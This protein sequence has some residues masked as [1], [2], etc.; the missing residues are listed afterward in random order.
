MPG[1]L[2][3]CHVVAC[4][5]GVMPTCARAE[6]DHERIEKL[7]QQLEQSTELIAR[8]SARI[9][10]LEQ[11]VHAQAEQVNAREQEDA[12]SAA[13]IAT[14]P[15]TPDSAPL[16]PAS[17]GI[18]L[19]AFADVGYVNSDQTLSDDRDSGFTMGNLD[20][21]LTPQIAARVKSLFELNFE[22]ESDGGLEVD[23]ERAQLGYTVGD[24][25][26]VWAGRFHTPFGYWNTAF[27]H[28]AQLQTSV[29]RPRFLEFEDAGG[30]LPA[31][32]VGLWGTGTHR[33]G[34]GRLYYDAYVG[35]G[36]RILDG[37]LD[38]NAVR[39]DNGQTALGLSLGY[40][41][42]LTPD[43]LLLG[44]HVLNENVNAYSGGNLVSRSRLRVYGGYAVYQPD[45]WEGIAEYYRFVNDALS[46]QGA[47]HSSWSGFVQLGYV[48]SGRLTPYLRYEEAIL[49]QSDPYFANLAE[50]RSYQRGV[51]GLRY[52][53]NPRSALKLE[54]DRTDETRDGGER[55][56]ELLGQLAIRF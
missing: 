13:R 10:Q 54:V 16:P 12:Q 17:D 37:E 41:F 49:D 30:I 50:G 48:F 24:S 31:H 9:N 53:L 11:S 36:D 15:A 8:L 56:N 3:G 34:N 1:I 18:T 27:H 28:G 35:N 14:V 52:D 43:S 2:F 44:V 29:G 25:L 26:T 55:F 6:S 21:Y 4:A 19:H 5:V 20:F 7:E 45:N 39:D 42:G 32:T 46:M 47:R 40:Q 51:L 33:A 22:Y 38:F 23:L